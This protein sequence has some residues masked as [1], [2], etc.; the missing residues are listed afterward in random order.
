MRKFITKKRTGKS[1]SGYKSK[2]NG[3]SAE[4]ILEETALYYKERGEAEILKRYEPYKRI[5][6]GS[7]GGMFKAVYTHKAGADYSV[8]LSDGR[9]GMLEVKSRESER[10]SIGAIDEEQK[11]MLERRDKAGQLA[12]ILVRL[13]GEWYLI[14]FKRWYFDETGESY[15]RKSHSKKQLKE[16]G[17]KLEYSTHLEI[18]FSSI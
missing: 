12:L 6:G 16:I 2:K 14:S 15:T 11:A 10:I 7:Q 18:P 1:L 4:S 3:Q 8:W 5:G 13:K 17:L 9:A